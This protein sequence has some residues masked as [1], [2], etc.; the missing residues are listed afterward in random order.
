MNKK[1]FDEVFLSRL[2]LTMRAIKGEN[3]EANDP[4]PLEPEDYE[5]IYAAYEDSG[6]DA[7]VVKQRMAAAREQCNQALGQILQYIA[8]QYGSG[9][10]ERLDNRA[11]SD[12][13]RDAFVATENWLDEVELLDRA[14]M[15]RNPLQLCLEAH[16]RLN[17]AML[18]LHDHLLWPIARR[19]APND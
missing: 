5:A 13:A 16:Y 1:I 7:A 10:V 9:P 17:E 12:I 19:I 2:A 18:E 4:E 3:A 11:L 8:D 14:V 15:P 6:G